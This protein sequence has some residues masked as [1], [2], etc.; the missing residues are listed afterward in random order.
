LARTGPLAANEHVFRQALGRNPELSVEIRSGI[1]SRKG[2]RLAQLKPGQAG[3]RLLG[4]LSSDLHRPWR[5]AELHE[6]IF[7]GER[8]RPEASADRVHKTI[9]RLRLDL[10]RLDLPLQI[11]PRAGGFALHSGIGC[12]LLLSRPSP[13]QAVAGPALRDWVDQARAA[14]GAHPFSI[15]AAHDRLGGA[16]RSVARRLGQGVAAGLLE[17]RGAGPKTLYLSAPIKP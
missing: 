5:L 7:P 9:Q 17:R 11:I 4:A 16:R 8:Y 15:G 1:I 12:N 13:D 2:R 14:F 10:A 3:H 6:Q